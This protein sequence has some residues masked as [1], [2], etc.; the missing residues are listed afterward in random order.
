MP[1]L[2]A[3][4]DQYLF[5]DA[6]GIGARSAIQRAWELATD[7]SWRDLYASAFEDALIEELP[8]LSAYSGPGT[9]RPSHQALENILVL[10]LGEAGAT[11]QTLDQGGRLFLTELARAMQTRRLLTIQRHNLFTDEYRQILLNLFDHAHARFKSVLVQ[12][13][14]VFSIA[15]ATA[16]GY[17]PILSASISNYLE[18]RFG[19]PLPTLNL[20]LP[21]SSVTLPTS[22]SAPEQAAH[23]A[24]TRDTL[25]IPE[26]NNLVETATFAPEIETIAE[27]TPAARGEMGELSPEEKIPASNLGQD[28]APNRLRVLIATP[29]DVL[30][31]RQ[32]LIDLV[33][34][35]DERARARFGLELALIH[36]SLAEQTKESPVDRA[37]IFIGAL[38]LRFG[39]SATETDAQGAAF[40]A[41]TRADF[42]RALERASARGE[43]WLHAVIY[44]S[45]R[46]PVDLLQLDLEQYA[47]VQQFFADANMYAQDDLVRVFSTPAEVIDDARA[48]LDAWIYNC[49]LDLAA[50]HAEYGNSSLRNNEPDNALAA[51]NQAIALYRELDRPENELAVWMQVG[52]L[53]MQ[54]QNRAE[55]ADAYETAFRLARRI[56]EDETAA[57]ALRALGK[58]RTDAGDFQNAIHNFASAR[59]FLK[60]DEEAYRQLL[61]DELVAYQQLGD[62]ANASGD[63]AAAQLHYG[64]ARALA[65]ELGDSSHLALVWQKLGALAEQQSAWQDALIAY[66]SALANLNAPEDSE[67]RRAI[68][69]A[70]ARAHAQL[71]QTARTNNLL[72]QAAGAFQAALQANAQGSADR[73]SN[74]EWFTALGELASQQHE[75][76]RGV[77]MYAQ[78]LALLDSPTDTEAR[79]TL[80][81]EQAKAY[82]Q[83][84]TSHQAANSLELAAGAYRDALALYQELELR[85]EQA[86]ALNK[87]GTIASLQREWT[88]ADEY[89]TQTLTLL[90]NGQD[91]ELY[92]Q[93][94]SA[95]ANALTQ[96]GDEFRTAAQ[97]PDAERVYIQARQDLEVV[98][99][100][101]STGALLF[102]LGGV[103]AAQARLPEALAYFQQARERISREAQPEL[104]A[105]ILRAQADT[106]RQLGESNLTAADF[107]AAH[108]NFQQQLDLAQELE[109]DFL[110]AD[111]FLSLG[112]VAA[113]Q[114]DWDNAIDL[115]EQALARL[116]DPSHEPTRVKVLNSQL[117]AYQ[118]MGE[119]ERSAGH[120]PQGQL[121]YRSAL[122]VAQI[123][124]ERENEADLLFTLGQISIQEENWQEALTNLRRALG[125]YNLM[126]SA[127]NRAQVIWNI[128]RAQR[129]Q[130]HAHMMSELAQARET[131]DAQAYINALQLARELGDAG[132]LALASEQL[133]FLANENAE[134]DAAIQFFDDALAGLN[135]ADEAERV[136]MIQRAQARA[137]RERSD[138]ARRDGAWKDA[139]ADLFSALD[140]ARELNDDEL[141]AAL[142]Y[143]RGLVECAQARWNEALDLFDDAFDR[144][145][146]SSELRTSIEKAKAEAFIGLGDAERDAQNLENAEAAYTQAL[147][148]ADAL[149][150]ASV[151][152]RVLAALGDVATRQARWSDALGQLRQAR[153]ITASL[154][155]PELLSALDADIELATHALQREQ[156]A[157]AERRGDA[158]RSAREFENARDEYAQAL[159]LAEQ[160]DDRAAQAELN[161]KLGFVATERGAHEDA[162]ASYRAAASL[163]DA[164]E[165]AS[166]R[167]ALIELQAHALQELGIRAANDAQW[168]KA[169]QYYSQAIALMDSP[170]HV[171]RRSALVRLEA[172]AL[173]N[174]G[175]AAR[176]AAQWNE[177]LDAYR[178]AVGLFRLIGAVQDERVAS[179]REGS[180]LAEFARAAHAEHNF[181]TS[182]A[183]YE[184]AVSRL[185]DA[186]AQEALRHV[187][188]EQ[189][190]VF[191]DSGD[192]AARAGNWNEARRAYRQALTIA[193]ELN[194]R[195]A[196]AELYQRIG[197]LAA[198]ENDFQAALLSYQ[199]ALQVAN[200]DSDI[201]RAVL[202]EQMDL[203]QVVGTAERRAG[204]LA[205]AETD[206]S[207]AFANAQS[208]DDSERAA[209]FAFLLGT[210]AAD[211]KAWDSALGYYQLALD[212][213][214]PDTP[215]RAD[216]KT[217]QAFAYQQ[218]G[219]AQHAG[220]QL[221]AAARAFGAGLALAEELDDSERAGELLYRLGSLHAAHGN[222]QAALDAYTR[223]QTQLADSD[224]ET[225]GLVEREREFAEQAFA[226]EQ[227][228]A[229]FDFAIRARTGHAWDNAASAYRT[230]LALAQKLDD[231]AA[232]NTARRALVSLA[233]ERAESLRLAQ[234]WENAERAAQEYSAVA[235]EFAD[236]HAQSDAETLGAIVA[237]E[238]AQAV[239]RIQMGQRDEAR[240]RGDQAYENAQWD[241]AASSYQNGLELARQLEDT[242]STG[243]F[244]LALGQ[245]ARMQGHWQGAAE[246]SGAAAETFARAE[247][248]NQLRARQQQLD[249]LIESANEFRAQQNWELARDA[250]T[251]AWMVA[252]QLERRSDIA[253]LLRELGAVA[254]EQNDL[255]TAA[256]YLDQS[257]STLPAD[258]SVE[259]AAVNA[260]QMQVWQRI[261]AVQVDA[262]QFVNAERA[263]A[264]ALDAAR[265]LGADKQAAQILHRLGLAQSAQENWT[266]ASEAQQEA[267]ALSQA[268]DFS[269]A[270]LP[271]V[272]ALADALRHAGN[273]DGA[274]E[275]Y[276][277][278]YTLAQALTDTSRA[279]ASAHALGQIASAETRWQ[280]AV[281]HYDAAREAY[282]TLGDESALQ[283]L[284]AQ[285][286]IA[287]AALG[288]VRQREA[289]WPEAREAYRRALDLEHELGH[290]S[291]DAD[292]HY[293]LGNI[294]ASEEKYAD[295]IAHYERASAAVSDQESELRDRILAQ[296]AL[297]LQQLGK[298]SGE[299]H[300]WARAESAFTRA[301]VMSEAS[302]NSEQIANLQL[303]LGRIYFAQQRFDDAHRAFL[304]ALE[305]DRADG[306]PL[307]EREIADFLAEVRLKQ[308]RDALDHGRSEQAQ[309]FLR[310][311]LAYAK[312]TERPQL[313]GE[314]LNALG[315]EANT[316][317]DIERA[318]GFFAD[319]GREFATIEDSAS[320]REISLTQLALLRQIAA[321]RL[322][323]DE[324][325]DAEHYYRRAA[326][327]AH[328]ADEHSHDAELHFALGR[329][330]LAQARHDEAL[331][332]F[333]QAD[334][335]LDKHAPERA[336]LSRLQLNT[337]EASA[338]QAMTQLRWSDAQNAFTRAAQAYDE[339]NELDRAGFAWQQLAEIALRQNDFSRALVANDR[340]AAR[341]DTP[342]LKEARTSVL[343]QQAQILM[344]FG[345]A[346]LRAGEWAPAREMYDRAFA[347]AQ[348]QGD[349]QMLAH[350]YSQ[351]SSLAA[352]RQEWDNARTTY[353][354]ALDIYTEL[355]DRAAQANTLVRLGEMLRKA[356]RFDDALNAHE[357]ARALYRSL[358]NSWEEAGMLLQLGDVQQ[359]RAAWDNALDQYL[360]ALHLYDKLGAL[361]Q[362]TQVYRAVEQAVQRAKTILSDQVA[363]RA[364]A[365]ADAGEWAEAER[366][367]REAFDL[368][369]DPHN[370]EL[371]AKMQ[372]QIGVALEAQMRFD[373]AAEAF[374][375][376]VICF[377]QLGLLSEQVR[378]LANLGDAQRSR[379]SWQEAEAAYTQ[380]LNANESLNDPAR[381]GELYHS[382]GLVREALGDWSS[383][384]EHYR[385][386][387]QIFDRAELRDEYEGA[388]AG[389][390]RV[391][392]GTRDAVESQYK[393]ALQ[394]A[395]ASG[396]LAETGELLNSLGLLAARD[397]KWSEAIQYYRAAAETFEH[398]EAR[399]G[400]FAQVWRTAQGTVMNNIGEA[401]TQLAAWREA[402]EAFTRAFEIAREIGD[403]T[404]QA[405]LLASLG[406]TAQEL[407]Q[408]PR[409][410]DLNLRA[411]ESN[412]A[413]GEE[414]PRAELLERVGN[415][416]LQLDQP[417]A[418]EQIYAQ[419]LDAAR[420]VNDDERVARLV[421]QLDL[422]AQSRHTNGQ[423]IQ[424]DDSA[425]R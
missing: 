132:T 70:K 117:A 141:E 388:R 331:G 97:W 313:R 321:Q 305:L 48:R 15:L 184:Q 175:D 186:R 389:L 355:D 176:D 278:A 357:R 135:R 289:Q 320:W 260:Q 63:P 54:T 108:A 385:S 58:L 335:L 82:T 198:R 300:D 109:A 237:R 291:R 85:G 257:L 124:G 145:A 373:Q 157:D 170:A 352:A 209:E 372:Y 103:T 88:R 142:E 348:A 282:Q 144:A 254:A 308:G 322:D 327:L 317:G 57:H 307:N 27:Q 345:D 364:Q 41:G 91:P 146:P 414:M 24:Q 229:Q 22:S 196:Q 150:D 294:S 362:K 390:A 230:A 80:L 127:P 26:N 44:R 1:A 31:E 105:D 248:P 183:W 311:A 46:P 194:D 299:M 187:R 11:I 302:A 143:R 346:H 71:A 202:R 296:L 156:Q 75:D 87:L 236:P 190:S 131:R 412:R 172:T 392:R 272:L 422:I 20:N 316:R 140:L 395:R 344:A 221:N 378:A 126:P 393:D 21:S 93:T 111:A 232:C 119:R 225:G 193:S 223:A 342:D 28:S 267:Y 418:A 360:E 43:T 110:E 343:H 66:D 240:T 52:E 81:L 25:N 271:I 64:N 129:G 167:S 116:Q 138:Q 72:E 84:G 328:A 405:V 417:H 310:Q 128:G 356:G 336:E 78:A 269:E 374:Q 380:A 148:L 293:Q 210:L 83:L 171:E 197:S 166:Q 376:A 367:Y 391:Q 283:A 347:I 404:S 7:S 96:I 56:E 36:P 383:A 318:I 139:N 89:F 101:A 339:L 273:L 265:A 386:A 403:R 122:T 243:E 177:A 192:Q 341:L 213:L 77:Q 363:A 98:G 315:D 329:A 51:F 163:Y 277:R 92:A 23:E 32:L 366:A 42:S 208:L 104:Y 86:H 354:H 228:S 337:L 401:A 211:Q 279:A 359:E 90:D 290:S 226:R 204:D 410:L 169:L 205:S 420:A 416:Q 50:A 2:L 402:D 106:L 39:V 333:D 242:A 398:L 189:R 161:A 399:G 220:G 94:L 59:T 387:M 182:L 268:S 284:D 112:R 407:R 195:S 396:N 295:A 263:F 95:R 125:I 303:Q 368:Y 245:V 408:L 266:G 76:E 55:V 253:H 53:R 18:R 224:S 216:V 301:L 45:I 74:I 107:H 413:L 419:A 239:R 382:L 174:I 353:Q 244:Q 371:Q 288:D 201:Q 67:T 297:S 219:D 330:L 29:A 30:P 215:P 162:L 233:R 365:H 411:L 100:A 33:H 118:E 60:R 3:L 120:L 258:A 280:E 358:N 212:S 155:T 203:Y 381:A 181:S 424:T 168:A 19:A 246:L 394:Q 62:V 38:W 99:A 147:T 256:N 238:H 252:D 350:L 149:T 61:A 49:A 274:R 151:Q 425:L 231:A 247:N 377:E 16:T 160:L 185:S 37:D 235:L 332:E 369:A 250:Y 207:R 14:P 262:A 326:L 123:L 264:R 69:D 261:G 375:R 152:A 5:A 334:A 65:E 255:E 214:P 180:V 200:P 40:F 79:R 165:N 340:A 270:Q 361:R 188:A 259:R 137:Y 4:L 134:W 179:E 241:E 275:N 35:L 164:P 222:W 217:Y 68:F 173:Q 136:A 323:A 115:Y 400:E 423:E 9:S 191:R 285:R 130:K 314:I 34:E 47:R 102:H 324:F 251:R 133:G 114:N 304:R 349:L 199:Y 384:E 227:L 338:A 158:Y 8:H 409:A 10:D 298:R 206:F 276:E 178:R 281:M 379:H 292:L 287:F 286:G 153:E 234:D 154:E 13:E 121:A 319:A 406:V 159:A 17:D 12:N 306:S 6:P 73:M 397:H 415:I 113:A 218:L 325:V 312:F 249:A 370:F 351:L 421:K 309:A